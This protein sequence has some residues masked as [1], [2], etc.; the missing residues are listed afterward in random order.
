MGKLTLAK[1]TT[2]MLPEQKRVSE[3]I[4]SDFKDIIIDLPGS[5]TKHQTWPGGYISHLEEAMNIAVVLY[6]SLS[7]KRP[8]SFTLSDTLFALFLHDFDKITRYEKV[9]NGYKAKGEYNSGYASLT[10]K[11]LKERYNY[12]LSNEIFN[13]LKYAHGEGKDYHPTD[14]IIMP[15]GTLVH[16]CDIISAR[17]W[18]D[19][20]KDHNNW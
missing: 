17:I 7:T 2:L 14:R 5:T 6:K 8:L 18:F 4:M 12:K 19:E 20:G 11:L 1:L 13:A 16:C 15:L 3:Q 9:S 10:A